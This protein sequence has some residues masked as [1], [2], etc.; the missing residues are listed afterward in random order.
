MEIISVI[1]RGYC[2][3]VVRAI[4]IAKNTVRDNP[5]VPV[6][7]LGM[8]V[9]NQYVVHAC[10]QL[11]IRFAEEAGRSRYDLLDE[12]DQ[13]IVIFTAHGVSDEV[14]QKALSKG[15]TVIDATC[16]D[17]IRTHELVRAHCEDHGD[18]LYIGKQGHPEAEGTVSLSDRVHL[19][20]SCADIEKLN[21]LDHVLITNQ[22][23]LSLLD[24]RQIIDACLKKYPQAETASEICQ[25][26]RIRQEAVMHLKDIDLLIVVGDA[27]SNNSHQLKEIGLKSGIPEAVLIDSVQDLTEDMIKE[28]DRIAVTS[29]SSTPNEL[30]KQVIDYLQE[31][32]RD[33]H[34]K[35]PPTAEVTI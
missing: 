4:Q 20:T 21:H 35:L 19:I 27:R 31:Y 7:M 2:Q 29:G 24:C 13:G 32:A 17:V 34:W 16:P 3:G 1:P 30:T 23:T 18:V 11:G 9:H 14:R 8:I 25:A 6:T 10:Q 22:T 33:P 15:L 26:T 12:I 28:K 5:G